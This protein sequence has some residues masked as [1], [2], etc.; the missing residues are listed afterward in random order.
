MADKNL[1]PYLISCDWLQL[2]LHSTSSFNPNAENLFG[3]SFVDVGHG[4]K[5]FKKIY[6]V[7]EP[8]GEVIGNISFD[9][10]LTTIPKNTVIFKAENNVL[11]EP[12]FM[13]RFSQ[14]AQCCG[15][16]YKGITRIDICYDS[17]ELYGG[18]KH[19]TLIK[20]FARNEYLKTG[21]SDYSANYNTGYNLSID[22]H[23][24]KRLTKSKPFQRENTSGYNEKD[25]QLIEFM[26]QHIATS[27]RWGSRSSDV[28]VLLYNKTKELNE[29][30]MKHY[31]VENW[32][33][34]GIDTEKD[35]YRIEL[36]IKNEGKHLKNLHT[37]ERFTLSINDIITQELL[38]QLF[39]DFSRKH[40]R[41]FHFNGIKK[42][43]EMKEVKIL[44]LCK[45]TIVRPM[46]NPT[47]KDYTRMAKVQINN[48]EKHIVENAKLSNNIVEVLETTK[49]YYIS[50]YGLEKH[51]KDLEAE[52]EHRA[53]TKEPEEQ[54]SEEYYR[55]KFAGINDQAARRAAEFRHQVEQEMAAIS[56]VL[57]D[58]EADI[59][60]TMYRDIV[61][62]ER[63]RPTAMLH[64]EE[65]EDIP[66]SQRSCNDCQFCL[67]WAQLKDKIKCGRGGIVRTS[68]AKYCKFYKHQ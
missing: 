20:K 1:R 63:Y 6:N 44:S 40:F 19:Q 65:T 56:A 25:A 23:G 49:K 57:D 21:N 12:L 11:Y 8:T 15:L 34:A 22:R 68:M 28:C 59:S 13:Q 29:N 37:G 60:D 5:Q 61:D 46:R 33:A 47:K 26:Q 67:K 16:R 41:F 14:F 52:K 66:P 51:Y 2:Y 45:Q 35:V 58:E 39:H 42:L 27:M 4:S 53:H 55:Q 3:Y 10:Y 32:K 54:T 64:G 36:S 38:E 17:T 31:I 62:W 24:R 9:P 7:V 18:L 30:K 50:S 43:Q 48:L